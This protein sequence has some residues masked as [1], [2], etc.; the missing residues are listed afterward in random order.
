M[1]C[2]S[3]TCF[4]LQGGDLWRLKRV[5]LEAQICIYSWAVRESVGLGSQAASI[6]M[7]GLIRALCTLAKAV[8]STFVCVLRIW[9]VMKWCV[10]SIPPDSVDWV[11]MLV[12]LKEW[13][14]AEGICFQS[15]KWEDV[16]ER[17]R[18]GHCR[19]IDLTFALA[20]L[21]LV[22]MG[23]SILSMDIGCRVIN[24]NRSIFEHIWVNTGEP[25]KKLWETLMRRAWSPPK[26]WTKPEQGLSHLTSF[27]LKG[28]WDL[29][30]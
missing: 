15:L 13:T 14:R 22:T 17:Q 19:C 8:G 25:Q 26:N 10:M 16:T 18:R 29:R 1:K 11:W 2:F 23:T 28:M 3:K 4:S 12:E 7:A 30:C 24:R 27:V 5:L 6:C 9:N 20:I 21:G